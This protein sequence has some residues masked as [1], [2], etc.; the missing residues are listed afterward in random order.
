[1][2]P[3]IV[4]SSSM[5]VLDML[6]SVWNGYHTAIRNGLTIENGDDDENRIR[7]VQNFFELKEAFDIIHKTLLDDNKS[8]EQRIQFDF[9]DDINLNQSQ[10]EYLSSLIKNT[11]YKGLRCL[12][13]QELII[14]CK[15]M[16]LLDYLKEKDL[17]EQYYHDFKEMLQKMIDNETESKPSNIYVQNLLD[18]KDIVDIL[19]KT[20]SNGN[21]ICKRR[22]V[23]DLEYFINL[24][25]H[26]SAYLSLFINNKLKINKSDDDSQE[27]GIVLD[28][29]MMLADYLPE[30]D[31]F[32]QY[33]RKHFAQRLPSKQL[34]S[35]HMENNMILRL[36]SKYDSQFTY[37]LEGMMKDILISETT[38]NEF[39]FSLT[40]KSFDSHGI[41]VSMQI[42][43]KVCWPFQNANNQCILPQMVN[44]VYQCFYNFCINIHN[45][46]RLVLEP[47]LGTADVTSIFYD[48]STLDNENVESQSAIKKIN[49]RK[50]IL[51]V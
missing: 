26:I 25:Q 28:K 21:E 33:Y 29:T 22:I 9:E 5:H 4:K 40:K 14:L 7:F 6:K 3:L 32:E 19:L 38:M 43:T 49:E 41:D 31:V 13:K 11:F 15:A 8:L 23:S 1:M 36:R 47:S 16:T 50:H 48:R 39:R 10:V 18:L 17:F 35:E 30:K 24:N 27:I 51:Q 46:R 2:R 45:G 20:I 42:L 37:Q 34:A 44:E 12:G